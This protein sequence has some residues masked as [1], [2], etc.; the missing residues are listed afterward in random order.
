MH[1]RLGRTV[2]AILCCLTVAGVSGAPVSGA[3]SGGIKSRKSSPPA[4]KA[5]AP[6]KEAWSY[7]STPDPA[8]SATPKYRLNE[9][10]FDW[11]STGFTK[12]ASGVCRSTAEKIKRSRGRI[13]LLGF[14]HRNEPGA[15]RLAR[16]RAETV[17]D[18]FKA[19]GVNP[20]RFEIASFGSRYSVADSTQSK[21][22][23]Q[24]RRVE[25][26]VISE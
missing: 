9:I 5:V 20:D 8:P 6:K 25:I 23:E 21:K 18:C 19:Q 17:K 16:R 15:H 10:T 7:N 1:C 12:E 11:N 14:T 22:M 24:E 4:S 2:L 3:T 13:L 26:W